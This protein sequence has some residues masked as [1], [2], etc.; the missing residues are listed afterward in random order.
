MDPAQATECRARADWE[1]WT[2]LGAVYCGPHA[3][4]LAKTK[5]VA[6]GPRGRGAHGAEDRWKGISRNPALEALKGEE[7]PVE[8]QVAQAC[9]DKETLAAFDEAVKANPFDVKPVFR[10]HPYRFELLVKSH[11][12]E[13][14]GCTTCH[15]GEG[16]QTKGVLHRAFRHGEDDHH[17]NDPSPTK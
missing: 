5:T 13:N 14:F 1:K 11:V 9:T 7:K 15:G 8:E 12:P 4:S 10:T 3:R 6:E 2:E 17:W 16:A